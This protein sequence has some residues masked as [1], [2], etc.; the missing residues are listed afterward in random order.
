ML[1]TKNCPTNGTLIGIARTG[2]NPR[3][4]SRTLLKLTRFFP[5]KT[6]DPTMTKLLIGTTPMS[7]RTKLS[8]V[9]TKNMGSRTTTRKNSSTNTIL[10]GKE[11]I[12]KCLVF[13]RMPPWMKLR[14]LIAKCPSSTIPKIIRTLRKPGRNSTKLTRPTMPYLQR[15]GEEIMMIC[16]SARSSLA[17]P[18]VFSKISG[19]TDLTK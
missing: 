18:M 9:S 2:N 11:A 15:Q 13:L 10:T 8:N 19:G 1:L 5:T 14:M 4:N 12:M 6:E 16:S 3:R 7:M 17:G